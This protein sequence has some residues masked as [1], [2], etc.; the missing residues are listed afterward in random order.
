MASIQKTVKGYRVQVQVKGQRDSAT[1]DTKREAQLWAA[2]KE[3]EFQTVA[4][5]KAGS[6]TTT[7]DAFE[8]YKTEVSVKHKGER[9]ESVRLDKMMREFPKLMLDKVGAAHI[10]KWRDSRLAE[11]SGSSVLR[12]MK[13]LSAVFERCCS[14]EWRLLS[15]NPC[16][17]VDRPK[18]SPHRKRTISKTE[19]KVMLRELGYPALTLPRHAVAHAFLLALRT[20]MRQGELA[21]IEWPNV[22]PKFIHTDSKSM[23]EFTRDVPLS[24][25][26]RRIVDK[27]RGYNDQSMFNITAASI[28]THFRNAKTRAKLS[29]FTFHDS[30]HTAATW[31]GRSGK[32]ELIELCKAFG[33]KDPK[34]ALIYFNPTGD[35]LADKLDAT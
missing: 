33:W 1:F 7:H 14:V 31:I 17:G 22:H 10:I 24:V 26:A 5:G 13:L 19:I 34:H 21:A 2:Q 3:I 25:K 11:V 20:G 4:K 8:R 30:R 18:E 28:D 32:F 9:W 23:I 16:K 29:G 35:D 27:M 12:E 15:A 6:I